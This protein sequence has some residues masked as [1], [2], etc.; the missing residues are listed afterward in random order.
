M[1]I[2]AGTT[3]TFL[4]VGHVVDLVSRAGH[5]RLPPNATLSIIE[6]NLV[7]FVDFADVDEQPA[8]STVTREQLASSNP[9]SLYVSNF[10][11]GAPGAVFRSRNSSAQYSHVVRTLQ[12]RLV[13]CSI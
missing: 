13:A 8:I 3:V 5:L 1:P 2:R 9:N 6:C 12:V 7:V 10:L 4:C 11:G